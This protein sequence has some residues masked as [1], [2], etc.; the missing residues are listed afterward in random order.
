MVGW[1]I[2]HLTKV[3]AAIEVS[4][5]ILYYLTTTD[6]PFT[7]FDYVFQGLKIVSIVS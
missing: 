7:T 3:S 6:Q 1:Y 5:N 4:K 2:Y